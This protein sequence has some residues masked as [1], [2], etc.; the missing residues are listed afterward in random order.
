MPD[1][2]MLAF[3]NA[4]NKFHVHIDINVNWSSVAYLPKN[5]P[6]FG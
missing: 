2:K 4:L 5:P 3:P 6:E 1:K